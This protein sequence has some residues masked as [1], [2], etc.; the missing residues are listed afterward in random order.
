MLDA[1]REFD[2][3]KALKSALGDEFSA[4]FVKLKMMEWDSYVSHFS[5]WEK[6][7]TLDV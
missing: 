5:A 1:L 6:E 3:D 7:N 2:S 4:A